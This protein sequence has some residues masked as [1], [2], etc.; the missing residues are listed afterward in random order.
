MA[1][2]NP[3]PKRAKKGAEL[4]QR[5]RAA[6]LNAFDAV[7][8]DGKLIS[9]VLAEEFKKNPI[10]FMELASKFAPK[11]IS[12]EFT[13]THTAET[14]TDDELAAIATGGSAGTTKAQTSPQKVH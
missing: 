6:V 5:C 12:G 3:Q 9:E 14:M 13:H 2:S 1:N 4:V 8:R 11:E 7:E 10:K